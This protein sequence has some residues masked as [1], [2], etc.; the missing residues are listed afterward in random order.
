MASKRIARMLS[1]SAIHRVLSILCKAVADCPSLDLKAVRAFHHED[2]RVTFS[3]FLTLAV[4]PVPWLLGGLCLLG[5]SLLVPEPTIVSLGFAAL[6]MAIVAMSMTLLSKQLL[7]WGI[8]SVAFTLILRGL[9]P[10]ESK[11]LER[12]RFAR[13][14]E[15][16]P[17][18][19]V[20]RVHYEGAIWHARCQISDVA[21][22]PENGVTVVGREGNTLIVVPIPPESG[23]LH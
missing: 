5:L 13:V 16:I 1:E 19:G 11:E 22:S 9:V 17:P 8:L 4:G 2:K 12:S 7:V 10:K 15:L 18:G 6:V 21:I 20:G 23:P 14:C 3:T